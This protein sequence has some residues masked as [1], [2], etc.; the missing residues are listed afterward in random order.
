VIRLRASLVHRSSRSLQAQRN[1]S[2]KQAAP[3]ANAAGAV[4]A[5]TES[6]DKLTEDL[7]TW[8]AEEL[9]REEKNY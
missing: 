4:Q 5:L 7:I 2:I 8:L 3:T 9:V 6:S 1:F